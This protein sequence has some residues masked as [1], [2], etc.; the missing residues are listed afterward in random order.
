MRA[1]VMGCLVAGLSATLVSAT[2][3]SSGDL[4]DVVR[5][6]PE[7]QTLEQALERGGYEAALRRDGPWTL[8]APSDRA[9][10][11]LP[12]QTRA[13]LLEDEQGLDLLVRLHLFCG[14]VTPE[15]WATDPGRARQASNGTL[16]LLPA[17]IPEYVRA[18][19]DAPRTRGES[20]DG[21]RCAPRSPEVTIF[22]AP[23]S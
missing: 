6:S 22:A 17:L 14:Q 15:A 7:L 1:I 18:A 10:E 2:P 11:A 4:F 21:L 19:L 12:R 23:L 3:S 5:A 16:H 8:F 13:A 20:G 9:F